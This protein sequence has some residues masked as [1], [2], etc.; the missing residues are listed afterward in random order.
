MF[1]KG[2]RVHLH[3][4]SVHT[5]KRDGLPPR[6]KRAGNPAFAEASKVR[7]FVRGALVDPDGTEH[8]GEWHENTVTVKGHEL[9]VR[10]FAGLASSG[11]AQWWGIGHET[12][13]S[14]NFS[15]LTRMNSEYGT[16]SASAANAA[17]SPRANVSA[18]QAL[19]G[20]WTLS[21]SWQYSATQIPND[22]NL[23]CIAQ[24]ASSAISTTGASANPLACALSIATF[25]ASSK[26]TSQA[27]NVTY[28]WSFGTALALAAGLAAM[29]DKIGM[30]VY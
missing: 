18:S 27:L 17:G 14:G 1:K 22:V 7:G 6:A 12:A 23:N 5:M 8:L 15:T 21:Q 13:A 24:H 2:T 25:V 29:M 30:L 11:G 20:T 28:N 4:G 16:N 3:D 26:S 9:I 19:A 10:N